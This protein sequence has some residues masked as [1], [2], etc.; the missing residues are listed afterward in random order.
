MDTAGQH[1]HS[2]Q[3][4]G[5][6]EQGQQRSGSQW[7]Q[8]DYGGLEVS[9]NQGDGMEVY[10][11]HGVEANPA[12]RYI[13]QDP[14]A[15]PN[16]HS[17]TSEAKVVYPGEGVIR[18]DG[19]PPEQQSTPE[20]ARICGIP[21]KRF[22]I[23]ITILVIVIIGAAVGGGV[24]GSLA[25]RRTDATE[26][27]P[28]SP[29]KSSPIFQNSSIA[30]VQWTDD[31]SADRKQYRVYFQA[32]E[33][34]IM[35]ASWAAE[36]A[37]WLVSRITDEGADIR[38]GTPITAA[39]G[40]PHVN[41][42]FALVKNVYYVSNT[43]TVYER[44]SP[45]KEQSG[46]WGNDN[47]SGLSTVSNT[48]SLFSFWYQSFDTQSQI[49]SILYQDL[50]ENSLSIS[51][52]TSNETNDNPWVSI[53]KSIAIKDGASIASAP[54]GSRRDHRLYIS[55]NQGTMTQYEYNLTSD[56]LSNPTPTVFELAPHSPLCVS[57]QDNRGYFPIA[58]LPECAT[59]SAQQLTHLIMFATPDRSSLSLVSWNCSTGFTDLSSHI[60][61]LLQPDRIYLGLANTLT[62]M[63]AEDQRVY[64]LFDDGDGPGIEEW[65]VP[66]GA[67]NAEWKV[68]GKVPVMPTES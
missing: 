14:H 31:P 34:A 27:N 41:T 7:P 18:N 6:T 26:S 62:S 29:T 53:R 57:T 3:L 64:V 35:E 25:A 46:I 45:Y 5:R 40:Y 32:K 55:D 30:A 65:Q 54:I 13:E 20:P 9:Q 16:V 42:S 19:A 38:M 4:H 2:F 11:P 10:H 28:T 58:L 50:G 12:H 61:P 22:W 47:F 48:S 37:T 49:L 67:Q 60:Q 8:Q 39:V 51:K 15:A 59:D 1:T 63:D 68:I 17:Y 66:P 23:L 56:T 36:N 44:Q 24:G 33:G 43:R 52:Y 21:K